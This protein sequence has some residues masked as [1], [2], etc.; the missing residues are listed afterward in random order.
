ML[1]S[2]QAYPTAQ[3]VSRVADAIKRTQNPHETYV[4]MFMLCRHLLVGY[5]LKYTYPNEAASPSSPVQVNLATMDGK[6]E[7]ML[8]FQEKLTRTSHELIRLRGG[9]QEQTT[10]HNTR[11]R[12]ILARTWDVAMYKLRLWLGSKHYVDDYT[13]YEILGSKKWQKRGYPTLRPPDVRKIR[14]CTHEQS[15]IHVSASNNFVHGVLLYAAKPKGQMGKDREEH[16]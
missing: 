15:C 4:D 14:C 2:F 13:C 11:V 9:E 16:H 7:C 3:F 5:I 8:P 1:W 6:A 10:S 12:G